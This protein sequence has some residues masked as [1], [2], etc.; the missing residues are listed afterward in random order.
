MATTMQETHDAFRS[1]IHKM[2]TIIVGLLQIAD[3]QQDLIYK[4]EDI[5]S[6]TYEMPALC[7]DPHRIIDEQ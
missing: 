7:L 5:T 2:T 6:V 3:E 4:I 1:L